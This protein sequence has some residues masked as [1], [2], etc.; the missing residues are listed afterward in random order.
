MTN[1]K[2]KQLLPLVFLGLITFW[3]LFL[4]WGIA[5][6]LEQPSSQ[7]FLKSVDPVP[8]RYQPGYE[9]YL[10]KCSSCHIPVPPAVLPTETWQQILQKPEEH[11][12]K[13]VELVRL[14]QLLIWDYLKIFSR[15]LLPNEPVPQLMEQSRYFKALHPKVDL[16]KPLTFPTCITCH[17][18]AASFDYRTLSPAWENAP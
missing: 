8:T 4:G 7:N 11:Y 6:A 18:K 13:K 17:P 5:L 14:N 2:L 16:P 1:L 10:E 3:S 15:L 9:L 12:G